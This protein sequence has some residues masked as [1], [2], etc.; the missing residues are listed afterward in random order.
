MATQRRIDFRY[1]PAVRWTCIG[2]PD[3]VYK[4]L[5]NETGA[6]LYGFER[7][8]SRFG[9]FRF[10]RTVAFRLQTDR[11]PIKIEQQ[12]E[13]ARIPVVKTTIHYPKAVLEL[14]AFGHQH[15]GSQRTDIVLWSISAQPGHE[16]LTGLWLEIQELERR[17]VPATIAPSRRIYEVSPTQVPPRQGLN[18]LFY[19]QTEPS[20]TVP[21][22]GQL[23][24]ISTPQ[25]LQVASAFGFGP[26]SGLATDPVLVRPDQGC[27]GGLI[28]PLNHDQTED[29]DEAWAQDALGTERRFWQGYNLRPLGLEVPDPEVNDLLTACVRNIFQAREMKAGLPEFQVGPTVYR[30]LWIIDGY[31]F[32]EAAQYL[33]HTADALRGIEVLLRRVKPSGAIEERDLDTKD[34]ALA[35]TTM[36]R[37]CELAGRMDTLESLWPT[38]KRAVAYLQK[39]REDSKQRGSDAPEYGLLPASFGNGGLGGIRPEY[40]TALWALTSLKAV[41]GAAER[42]GYQADAECFQAAFDDLMQTFRAHAER[43]MQTL[44]DGTP[45]LPMLKPGSGEHHWIHDYAGTPKPWQRVNPGTATW[46][47]A[48][49]IYP[50]QVFAPDDP[51]VQVFCHLLDLIDNEEGIPAETG[52]L[53][54]QAVWNYAAS[55]YAH[56]WLYAGRPDKTIDYLYAFANHAAPT[57]V[58]REEQSFDQSHHGQIIGDMPHNWAS[59]EFIRLVRHL[60][61]FERG[62]VLEMLPALPPEWLVPDRPLHLENTPTRFGP[63]SL[64]LHLDANREDQL[65]VNL[66]PDWPRRLNRCVLHVPQAAKTNISQ[67]LVNGEPVAV[68]GDGTVELPIAEQIMVRGTFH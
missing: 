14:S 23:A 46:A 45:Y 57:R 29:L 7:E 36:V 50:G 10:K 58:W 25:P 35:L 31:F 51:L 44:A 32:L 66:N 16:L 40:T 54:H 47:F 30:G 26:A 27:R 65:E 18:E 43:D 20:D 42:L 12:T 64:S 4:T 49:A 68:T 19:V 60:L 28:L 59:V 5:V 1:A 56:V 48:Q 62:D 63:V 67:V 52:W 55:F 2:R 34:T 9:T 8:G 11:S 41:S 13:S 24:F 39:L 38:I 21:L 33:G 6:L 17:F 37:Q 22:P 3:D 53:P 61:V 15:N